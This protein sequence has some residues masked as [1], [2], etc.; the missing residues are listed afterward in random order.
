MLIK[1][2]NAL[3]MKSLLFLLFFI[4][5]LA[6]FAQVQEG[7]KVLD[8]DFDQYE[9]KVVDSL[10]FYAA[11]TVR[12]KGVETLFFKLYDR[13]MKEVQ[14]HSVD[15]IKNSY[16][17]DFVLIH[18]VVI[19]LN[20]NNQ[21]GE[22]R[23]IKWDTNFNEF[24]SRNVKIQ[25]DVFIRQLWVSD[26][27]FM[28]L[29]DFN[30]EKNHV[31]SGY[32]NSDMSS[33]ETLD[34]LSQSVYVEGYFDE[35]TQQFYLADRKGPSKNYELRI[36]V[37]NR[38]VQQVDEAKINSDNAAFILHKPTIRVLDKKEF[39]ISGAYSRPDSSGANG[40]YLGRF[41]NKNW[42]F[43]KLLDFDQFNK[44][45]DAKDSE[46]ILHAKAKKRKREAK[47]KPF[48]IGVD[49]V[50]HPM[51]YQDSLIYLYAD[52]FYEKFHTES[53]M[54]NEFGMPVHTSKQVSDGY[55]FTHGV[56]CGLKVDGNKF[57]D[58]VYSINLLLPTIEPQLTFLYNSDNYL[59]NY[60]AHKAYFQPVYHE[61]NEAKREELYW[62][63]K[64]QVKVYTPDI[65]HWYDGVYLHHGKLTLR[66]PKKLFTI[67]LYHLGTLVVD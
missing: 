28:M 34:Y 31:W 26:V 2:Y 25:R 38:V 61:V 45:Y 23:W 59:M 47:G 42:T 50:M 41:V 57:M 10:H 6:T 22:A 40:F 66:E 21:T 37:F 54:T 35:L 56:V 20:Y 15:L 48:D 33:L 32:L 55:Q 24:T 14:S 52:L 43:V 39:I 65:E 27:K 62:Y 49:L 7:K 51:V 36:R 44:F 16:L 11:H 67:D 19:A 64:D 30:G 5:S 4:F 60:W 8:F 58:D 29:G 46:V 17:T 3:K 63:K 18:G 53:V 1:C 12:E 9:V 13:K